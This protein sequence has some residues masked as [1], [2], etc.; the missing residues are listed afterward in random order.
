[1]HLNELLDVILRW[2]HLIAGIMW[3][4]N[5]MLFN[6]LDR[7]LEKS[8]E[9]SRLSQGKIFM[10]HSGAFY[11][12]EKKLLEPGEMPAMMHWFK[13]QNFST[14][15]TGI[16]LFIVVYYMNGA[17][18]LVDPSVHD[19]DKGVAITLSISALVTG[20]II[21]DALWRTIGES[22]PRLATVISV[23][24]LFGSI[25]AFSQ[26]FSGRA[27]YMQTGVLIG[28]L[29]TGNVWFCIVPSQHELINA[30]KAGRPQDPTL[31]IRAKH[32]SIHNNYLTFPLLF[33]MVSSHFGSA[34][35]S[36]Y[37]WLI[38][39]LVMIGG[40]GVRHFMNIRYRGGGK[41]LPASAWLFPAVGMGA[42]A[43][44][45]L[46]IVTRIDRA[47]VPEIEKPVSFSRVQEIVANRCVTCHSARPS[48]TMFPAPPV[49]VML[50]SPQQIKMMA[51]RIHVRAVEQQN[52]PFNNRTG[53]TAEER[54]ELHRWFI[55]GA[56]IVD[57]P[58]DPSR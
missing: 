1:M 24:M 22:N 54:G 18:V 11:D 32:R 38:L 19:V 53:M 50:D 58:P 23:V 44:A 28:T 15:A 40:A 51:T 7:N 21:Y 5:S 8:A 37:N 9:L 27:A 41:E 14:W 17:G 56:K 2:A 55:D 46:M 12:V 25:F 6:W 57:S 39:I 16:S 26:F 42:F 31:S 29:M 43:I 47:T 52:M 36:K 4:G 3:V 13:W 35:S 48:D 20:W 34:T 10:V 33:I 49:G 45:G 30:T